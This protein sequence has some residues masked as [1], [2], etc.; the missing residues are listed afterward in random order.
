M[1]VLITGGAGFVGSNLA[2]LYRAEGAHVTVL[3]NLKRR[4]AELNL[5]EFKKHGIQFVHGD[6]R[7]PSDM[8]DLG[9]FDYFVEASAE[10]SVHAG[11]AGSPDYLLHT[12]LLGSIHC[13]NFSRK[14][15]GA[16]I[17]LSTSRVYSIG[18]LT[19]IPLQTAGTRFQINGE[20]QGLSKK[21]INEDFPVNTARSLYGASKLCSEYL[22]QEYVHTYKIK[23]LINRCGVIAGPGQF[24][25]VDQ[26]VFTLWMANHVLK[27]SLQYTGFGGKGHQVRDLIHPKDLFQLLKK[28]FASIDSHNGDVFN[29]GGGNEISTSLLEW[30]HLAEKF[31]GNKIEIRSVPETAQVDI[32]YYV[33]D[34]SKVEKTFQWKPQISPSGIAQEICTWIQSNESVKNLFQ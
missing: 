6:I 16:M 5:A 22:L 12:N 28:Q 8:E 23:A 3:D 15:A 32:P 24:G 27:K 33:T 7:N 1:R 10:P 21:G 2:K 9:K 29:V 26:G 19:E 34:N 31:T 4:G 20:A 25:K 18:A 30:T 14:N 17:F 13:L 11:T